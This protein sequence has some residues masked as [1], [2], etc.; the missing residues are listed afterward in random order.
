MILVQYSPESMFCCLRSRMTSAVYTYVPLTSQSIFEHSTFTVYSDLSIGFPSRCPQSYFTIYHHS[1]KKLIEQLYQIVWLCHALIIELTSH[2]HE[3][4][5]LRQ[6]DVGRPICRF[7]VWIRA[8]ATYFNFWKF[9][10]YASNCIHT[11]LNAIHCIMN[12]LPLLWTWLM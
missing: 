3:P 9:I 8:S 12:V 1:N 6:Y 10:F 11:V 5:Y 7:D 4:D 2:D